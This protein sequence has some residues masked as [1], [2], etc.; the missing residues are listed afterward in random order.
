M[1]ERGRSHYTNTSDGGAIVYW[2]LLVMGFGVLAPSVLWPEW[3][4]YQQFK[5]AEVEAQYQ[6]DALLDMVKQEKRL[7]HAMQTD[8]GVIA[9]IAQRDLQFARDGERAILVDVSTVG[10][11]V[12]MD[13]GVYHDEVANISRSKFIPP[14]LQKLAQ[15]CPDLNYD[16]IFGS[17]QTRMI[18]I[19][20]STGLIAIAFMLF[21]V[22]KSAKES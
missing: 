8:P 12:F 7:L 2:M 10:T 6:L 16:Q 18:L 9:R 17:Q 3:R 5:E 14:V 4:D 15:L 21:G 22:R 20:M 13:R 19:A 11:D 1:S